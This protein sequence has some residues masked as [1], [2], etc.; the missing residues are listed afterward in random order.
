M[1]D[2]HTCSRSLVHRIFA[3][4]ASI[5][6]ITLAVLM[7]MR[8]PVLAV[9]PSQ[10]RRKIM[11]QLHSFFVHALTRPW[12][13]CVEYAGDSEEV[14]IEKC[15]MHI[16]SRDDG[17]PLPCASTLNPVLK[18][19]LSIMLNNNTAFFEVEEG[20]KTVFHRF[21]GN[22]AITMEIRHCFAHYFVAYSMADAWQRRQA[23]FD[24]W[25][26]V[27]IETLATL[28]EQWEGMNETRRYFANLVAFLRERVRFDKAPFA[29]RAMS[30]TRVASMA[31]LRDAWNITFAT[32][33]TRHAQCADL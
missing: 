8:D 30:A 12:E 26:L 28:T 17:L 2:P 18:K 20:V 13:F 24:N 22:D 21:I 5:H 29:E 31:A 33:D 11:E 9:V 3:T 1:A 7:Q 32:R 15:N 19:A 4:P 14:E 25:R 6:S 10:R 16:F 23:G 27:L